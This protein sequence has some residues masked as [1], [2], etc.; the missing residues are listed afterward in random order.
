MLKAADFRKIARDGLKGNWL[1]AVGAGIIAVLLGGCIMSKTGSGSSS[2]GSSSNPSPDPMSLQ[3][4]MDGV[5][6]NHVIVNFLLAVLGVTAFFAVLY[7]IVSLVIGGA[8]SM[9]YAKFN[10]NI[11][12]RT[13]PDIRDIFSEMGRFKTG[14]VMK[15]LTTLYI[16]LWS[17]LF[18]I[19]GIIASY[20]YAMTPYIL[21]ENP[22]MT[23]SQAIVA[24]KELMKGNKWRLF[25][26]E[27]SFIGWSMLAA[28]TLGIGMLFLRPYIEA[29]GAAFYR[30]IKWEK[31]KQQAGI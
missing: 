25:C 26:L 10:L 18:V 5:T 8:V 30:E 19:P 16:L 13:N 21:M 11:I 3:Q 9:G 2:G 29:A 23:A 28:I 17:L 4:A 1:L 20:S 24:S 27:F 7:L 15:F 14:F 12:N 31:M 6:A 22:D